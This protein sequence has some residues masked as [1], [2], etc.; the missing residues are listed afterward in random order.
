[1]KKKTGIVLMTLLA[2]LVMLELGLRAIGRSPTNMADGIADQYGDSFRLKKNVSKVMRFPAFSYTVHTN[3]FGFRDSAV[4]QRNLA[5]R[6]FGVFLGA[7]DVFG[8]GVDFEDS[9]VGVF[10]GEAS[11]RGLEVLNLAVGGHYFLDQE[12]LLKDFM[13]DSGLKPATIFLCV[14][15]LHIPKFDRRNQNVIVKN[16]YAI[17]RDGWR[18]A[19]LRLMAGNISSAYCFFRDAI[20]RIQERYFDLE[21]GEKSPEFLQIY[22]KGNPIRTPERIRKFEEYLAGFE[23]FCQQNDIELIYVYLPL[24]DSFNLKKLISQLG[25]DPEAYDAT[26]YEELM[27]S[28]CKKSGHRLITPG[29]ALAPLYDEGKVLR[30]KLDPHFNALANRVIGEYLAQDYFQIPRAPVTPEGPSPSGKK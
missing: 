11:K 12:F 22:A 1:M 25:A 29:L 28:H 16:G 15:A 20:R 18:V 13:K 3:E 4:G 26:F 14:N 8:N 6:R 24:S 7:S 9:F 17:D 19:Y 10:A 5:G 23:T 30:F 21:V 27:R 2:C